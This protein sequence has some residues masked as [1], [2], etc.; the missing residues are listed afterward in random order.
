[1]RL[2]LDPISRTR[3]QDDRDVEEIKGTWAA[4]VIEILGIYFM[5]EK[6]TYMAST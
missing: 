6:K 3:K 4:V 1:M 5:K 2:W